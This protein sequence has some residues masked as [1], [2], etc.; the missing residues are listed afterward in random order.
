MA[1]INGG[2]PWAE[3]P[4]LKTILN[5]MTQLPFGARFPPINLTTYDEVPFACNREAM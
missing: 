3:S 1:G 5:G 2:D 4:E